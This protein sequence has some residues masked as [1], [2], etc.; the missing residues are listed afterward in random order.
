MLYI[1][2]E[3]PALN[4]QRFKGRES[5][6]FSFFIVFP[7]MVTV[8]LRRHGKENL[9]HFSNLTAQFA[10]VQGCCI[11]LPAVGSNNIL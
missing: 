3:I 8:Y 4:L 10:H 5:A 9:F 11:R 6:H 7:I 1:T 2:L